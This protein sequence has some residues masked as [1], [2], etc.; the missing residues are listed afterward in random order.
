MAG[1]FIVVYFLVLVVARCGCAPIKEEETSMEGTTSKEGSVSTIELL[2]STT[3][4][5]FFVRLYYHCHLC[6]GPAWVKIKGLYVYCV[7]N[8]CVSWEHAFL[9]LPFLHRC[10]T[11]SPI[12]YKPSQ[13]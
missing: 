6:T 9:Y 10:E 1:H 12:S 7:H 3:T 4:C 2:V 5:L 8:A 13:V 11:I